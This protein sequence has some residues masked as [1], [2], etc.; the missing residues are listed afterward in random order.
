VLDVLIDPESK[1]RLDR[2]ISQG[3][4]E[5]SGDHLKLTRLGRRYADTV[6]GELF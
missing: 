1:A 5:F 6:A 4:L 3:L 2:L